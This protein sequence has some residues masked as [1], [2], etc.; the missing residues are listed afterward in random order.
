MREVL[1]AFA[2]P[3]FLSTSAIATAGITKRQRAEA[4][5]GGGLIRVCK[6][7]FLPPGDDDALRRL[8]ASAGPGAAACRETAASLWGMD[9]YPHALP[10]TVR[11]PMASGMRGRGL[12]RTR[13][14]PELLQL[15]GHPVTGVADTLVDIGASTS[16]L[17]RWIGD[18]EPIR[19][20][21]RV[22]L[23][24]EGALR[25]GLVTF[26]EI[27]RVLDVS[28]RRRP[29]RGSI[30]AVLARR[31]VGAAHT[32]SYLETRA[33]QRLR[34]GG[35]PTPRRQV[36]IHDAHGREI[37]RVD[38]LLGRVVIALDSV[39]HHTDRATFER[40]RRQWSELGALGFTVLVFT[41][42]H[43]ERQASFV[44]RVIREAIAMRA[45]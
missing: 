27:G 23:A 5:S 32:E 14:T 37:A 10:L 7:R 2:S 31:P 42:D 40:D 45:A 11:M 43:I 39:R 17:L 33:V 26:E 44:V 41:Y 8:I 36:P 20:L 9:G 38:L 34:D 30:E 4:V 18:Q 15:N 22:E 25:D 13:H 21:D 29:G 19:T 35:L 24:L 12:I 28:T 6:G 16:P 3:S 1:P